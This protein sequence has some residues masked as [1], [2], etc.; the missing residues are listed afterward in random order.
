MAAAHFKPW[1]FHSWEGTQTPSGQMTSYQAAT[2]ETKDN[3]EISQLQTQINA[4]DC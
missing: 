1:P 4:L 2:A 3:N